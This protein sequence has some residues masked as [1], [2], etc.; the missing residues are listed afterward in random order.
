MKPAIQK[1]ARVQLRRFLSAA[2]VWATAVAPAATQGREVREW[3]QQSTDLQSPSGEKALHWEAPGNGRERHT[4]YLIDRATKNA[5]EVL[6][7]SRHISVEWAPGGAAFFATDYAESDS[8]RCL[9]VVL[10]DGSPEKRDLSKGLRTSGP[11]P[12]RTWTNH[13]VLCEV[14]RWRNDDELLLRLHGYGEADPRGFTQRYR[15]SLKGT[16]QPVR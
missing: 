3:P 1:G 8:S 5:I 11:V 14:L 2:I 10:G 4:L 6:S 16:F 7:F 15:Y 13:H 12:A 9:V